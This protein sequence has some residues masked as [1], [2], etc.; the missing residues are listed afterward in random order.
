[1]ANFAC[2]RSGS[3]PHTLSTLCFKPCMENESELALDSAR[4][5]R[6]ANRVWLGVGGTAQSHVLAVLGGH[7]ARL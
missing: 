6:N 4:L 7:R 2:V 3:G 1:M 5:N